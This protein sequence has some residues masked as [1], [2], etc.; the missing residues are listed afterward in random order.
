LILDL[1]PAC[2]NYA[3]YA[4]LR[5]IFLDRTRRMPFMARMSEF[6]AML[7]LNLDLLVG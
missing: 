5:G 2:R 3:S 4:L 1:S 7:G 6:C